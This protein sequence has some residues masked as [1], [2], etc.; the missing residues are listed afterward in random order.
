MR[1]N[2]GRDWTSIRNEERTSRL[3]QGA[4]L[5]P[6]RVAPAALMLEPPWLF[7]LLVDAWQNATTPEEAL[8][9]SSP[10]L[11]AVELVTLPRLTTMPLLLLLIERQPVTL[12]RRT[13]MPVPPLKTARELL[14]VPTMLTMP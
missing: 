5:L 2:L 8:I 1:S 14:T 4:G 11:R 12:P 3:T 7:V 13:E 10:L 6:V 9:P